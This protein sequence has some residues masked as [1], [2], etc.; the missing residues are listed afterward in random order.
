[1]EEIHP[2]YL[3]VVSLILLAI[4]VYLVIQTERYTQ[5]SFPIYYLLVKIYEKLSMLAVMGS[6]DRV[7]VSI[8]VAY[9]KV[10]AVRVGGLHLS[11]KTQNSSHHVTLHADQIV[12]LFWNYPLLL[13]VGIS[14]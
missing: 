12:G 9:V 3:F 7:L 5:F 13:Q 11:G 6:L 4:I 8:I 2:Q 14:E 1:M 10:T